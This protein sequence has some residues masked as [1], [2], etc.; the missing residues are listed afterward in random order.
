MGFKDWITSPIPSHTLEKQF[1]KVATASAQELGGIAFD[2][3]TGLVTAYIGGR[4][5][6]WVGEKWVSAKGTAGTPVTKGPC[7]FAAGTKVSTPQ[8]DRVIESLKVGDV[9]WSKPEKGGK[10]FAAAILATHQ[11]SDQPI[12]RLKLKSVR[13]AG[14]AEGET[15]LVT[16]SHPF[17]V[18]AKHDF[19]PVKD[20]EPGD[21]LQSLADGDT[22]NTSSEVE[23]LELYLPEGKTYNLTVDVGHTFYVGELKTWV[24]NTGPCDLPPDYFAG[25][26]KELR[27]VDP[28]IPKVDVTNDFMMKP[29]N[30]GGVQLKYGDPDGVAGLIVN[31]DKAGVLGFEI[32]AALNHPYYDASGTDMFASAMQRLGNEGIK[33]NQI[34]GA[35]EAGTDS[36]NTARYLENIAN[37]MSKENAALNTWTGQIAQKYGYGKVE[38]I[39]TIG[40]INYVIFKK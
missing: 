26:A 37:G 1:D 35:W 12:Y 20:L 19:I 25:G 24:H 14:A 5:V 22:E 15:L 8:G 40:G 36:V 21:L 31:V 18:P 13:G 34:R 33:V 17:Y 28:P 9:V 30:D 38:K 16:P 27:R 7:C 3:A 10:P 39:E 23:S 4:A 29:F 11:R 6:E 32:R 2:A